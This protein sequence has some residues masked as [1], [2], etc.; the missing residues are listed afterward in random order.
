M[1][2]ALLLEDAPEPSFVRDSSGRTMVELKVPGTAGIVLRATAPKALLL[3]RLHAA[4]Q[5]MIRAVCEGGARV[6]PQHVALLREA[7]LAVLKE[8][9]G[10]GPA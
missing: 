5:A 2:L 7:L 8:E 3:L 10:E 9:E 6:D 1:A 4:L